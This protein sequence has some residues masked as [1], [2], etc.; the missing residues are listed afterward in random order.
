MIK[1][2]ALVQLKAFAR[3]DGL[4]LAVAWLASFALIMF[5]PQTPYGNLLA[6]ATPFIVGWRLTKFR[7]NA[8]DGVVSFRRAFAYSCYTFFYASLVFAMGQYIYFRFIDNGQMSNILTATMKE[9]AYIPR[10]GNTGKGTGFHYD[11]DSS[12]EANR[13]CN[14]FHDAEP[15]DRTVPEL[16]HSHD[17]ETPQGW[18]RTT[19][20]ASDKYINK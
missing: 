20:N 14:S 8:L 7:D 12:S 11:T 1:V 2:S 3:Q 18:K 5:S 15:N 17:D 6:I 4:I 10:A 13:A 9:L 16:A 19:G